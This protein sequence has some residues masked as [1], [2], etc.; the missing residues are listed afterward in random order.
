MKKVIFTF[1]VTLL[2][3]LVSNAQTS[4]VPPVNFDPGNSTVLVPSEYKSL[5]KSVSA[6]T[7]IITRY[8]EKAGGYIS[9]GF[10]KSSKV[11]FINAPKSVDTNA[12]VNANKAKPSKCLK[13]CGMNCEGWYGCGL[14]HYACIL[15][16]LGY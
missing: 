16:S 7:L 4:K 10:D 6:E 8:N 12:F 3:S 15:E 9:I 13:E 14:C 5:E 11:V 1:I 2:F